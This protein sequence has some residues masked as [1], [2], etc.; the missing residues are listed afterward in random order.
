[1]PQAS[2]RFIGI[3]D[4]LRSEAIK[5]MKKVLILAAFCAVGAFAEEWAGT[6]SDAHCGAMHADAS[7]KSIA[8]AKKCIAGGAA[9]VFLVGDKVYK[10]ENQDAIKGHEG[11][12]VTVTGKLTGDTVHVDSVK[13]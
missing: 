8:C 10:I 3:S 11:H 13:M 4:I 9:A 1:M 12:K 7:E 5:T 6:I 2:L